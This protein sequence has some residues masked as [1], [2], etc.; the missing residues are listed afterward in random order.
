MARRA[1]GCSSTAAV[2][3]RHGVESAFHVKHRLCRARERPNRAKLPS[4]P[5]P[6]VSR[7]ILTTTALCS[8]QP[9]HVHV[10]H[11]EPALDGGPRWPSRRRN[12][13]PGRAF[14]SRVAVGWLGE[15]DRCGEEV[16][17]EATTQ[18]LPRCGMVRSPAA[19]FRVTNGRGDVGWQG[20]PGRHSLRRS[21]RL[22]P[23]RDSPASRVAAPTCSYG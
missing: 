10:S 22:Q 3:H 8:P 19:S 2:E 1:V 23:G 17:R 7:W 15:A 12:A 4:A 16:R 20:S 6:I 13:A 11:R 9:R 21:S 14:S 18:Q 5:A